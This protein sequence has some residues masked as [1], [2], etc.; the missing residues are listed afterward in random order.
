[1][2]EPVNFTVDGLEFEF[3][4]MPLPETC[5]GAELVGELLK[6]AFSAGG[7]LKLAIAGA[8]SAA[9]S[10]LPALVELFAPFCKVEHDEVS[11]G[12]A[13]KF[14]KEFQARAFNGKLDR[15]I[16]FVANCAAVEYGD[17]LGAGLE[18]VAAGLGELAQRYPSLTARSHSS[19]D[20]P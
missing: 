8:C 7:D 14:T 2:R 9:I 13:V 3:S 16:L 4:E 15:A 11:A 5:K 6:G 12:R 1:M 20:S 18:R 17:F 10:K 19:G